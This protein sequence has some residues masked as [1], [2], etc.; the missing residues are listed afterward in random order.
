LY[1]ATD[2][3][4]PSVGATPAKR[5]AMDDST[6]LALSPTSPSRATSA[7]VSSAIVGAPTIIPTAN[8]VISSPAWATLTCRSPAISAS[9]PATTNSVVSMRKVPTASTYTTNGSRTSRGAGAP[10]SPAG[11]AGVAAEPAGRVSWS[12]VTAGWRRR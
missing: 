8:T 5:T 9:R 3:A 2:I 6:G 7:T 11:P 4:T 10:P 1:A 12:E